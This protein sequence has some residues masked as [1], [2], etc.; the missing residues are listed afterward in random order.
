MKQLLFNTQQEWAGFFLRCILGGVMLPHGAQKLF[1]I[2]GGFGYK[3]TLNFFTGSLKL[4]WIISFLVIMI[5]FF[6]SIGMIMGFATRVWA[7]AFIA[8]MIG[9][10]VT[11]NWQHGLFM[12]WFGNQSGEGFEYHL[13]VIGMCL[14]LMFTGSGMF[15]IDGIISKSIEWK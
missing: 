3:V 11:T 12:N 10:I 14:A 1:G 8:I 4:P 7:V 9:A 13:L 6:G 5:E 2:F 15:S